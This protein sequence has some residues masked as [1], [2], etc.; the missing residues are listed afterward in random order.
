MFSTCSEQISRSFARAWRSAASWSRNPWILTLGAAALLAVCDNAPAQQAAIA[1][2]PRITQAID[3]GARTVLHGNVHP[4]ANAAN[5]R[6]AVSPSLAMNRMLLVLKRSDA[7]EHALRTLI[8]QQQDKRSSSFHQWLT[9]QR[10]GTLYGPNQSDI[11][12]VTTWLQSQGF[13][14]SNVSNGRTVIEFS[15]SAAQVES[16]FRTSIHNYAANGHA[17]QANATD[18]QIPTALAPVVA[19][20]ASINNFPRKPLNHLR[21]TFQREKSSGKVTQVGAVNPAFTFTSNGNTFYAIGPYDLATIYNITPLWNNS[22]NGSGQT[23]A[24]V[25]QTDI[26]PNDA[27]TFRTLFGLPTGGSLSAFQQ[28]YLN[29]IVNGPDPGTTGDE[30]EADIDT[31]WS[32]A[33]ATNALIDFVTSATTETTAGIDLSALY[34]VD[35]NLAPILS[36]SYGGCELGL[37]NAGN[38]FYNA[39]WEQAAAQGISVF[40]ASGDEGSPAC[41]VNSSGDLP[42]AA[43]YGLQVNGIGS[44]PYDTEIGGTDF[45]QLGN[46]F[47]SNNPTNYWNNTNNSTNQSSAKGYIPETTWND[48]CTNN[49]F[50]YVL[51][52]SVGDPVGLCNDPNAENINGY[53]AVQ[54]TGGGGGPSSCATQSSGGTCAAGYAKPSWQPASQTFNDNVRD[55]PDFSL[56]ASAGSLSGSFYIVCQSDANSDGQQCNLNSPYADFQGYGGT[57]VSTPI[58]A[59]LFAI[60]NQNIKGRVGNANYYLYNLAAKQ[61][62]SSCSSTGGPGSS[63]VFN[64]VV[65]GTIDQPCVPGRPNCL[66]ASGDNIGVLLTD[67]GTNY[68]NLNADGYPED[69]GWNAGTGYDY[70][71]G[72][73]SVNFNNLVSQ[74]ST[75]SFVASTTTLALSSTSFKHGTPVTANVTVTSNNGTPSGDVSFN[76]VTSSG[77]AVPNSS[78]GFA[79]LNNG[80]LSVSLNGLSS[81]Q[82]KA[83][84]PALIPVLPGGSYNVVAHYGGNNNGSTTFAASD[85]NPVAVNI[86]PEASNTALSVLLVNTQTGSTSAV[87]TATYGSPLI[88]KAAVTNTSGYGVPT[89]NV[90]IT[91]N[92]T[93]VTGSPFTLNSQGSTGIGYGTSAFGPNAGTNA[94]SASYSGDSS[95]NASTA[96]ATLTVTQAVPA[97]GLTASSTTVNPGVNVTFTAVV[98]TTSYA[99]GPTGSVTFYNGSTALGSAVPVTSATDKNGFPEATASFSTTTL[100][101]GNNSIT[102]VYSGDTNF[103]TVTSSAVAVTVSSNV[104]PTYSVTGGAVTLSAGATSG[105]TVTVTAS[106]TTGFSGTINFTASLTTE[107]AGAVDPPSITLSPTSVTLSSS[108]ASATSTATIST[109]APSNGALSYPNRDRWYKAAGGVALACMLFFGIPARRRAWRVMLSLLVFLVSV[110]GVGCGGGGGNN[111]NSG[112]TAGTYAFTI[113]ATSGSS[114]QTA[115]VTVNV[116]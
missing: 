24:I 9:P 65:R 11:Q 39:I 52:D 29:I 55:T 47:G 44:T 32:G 114:S 34:I 85:S 23:I 110:A 113:T 12:A 102:A 40:I 109:T 4:L 20:I 41:D 79:P 68:G 91:N 112:T 111:G 1:N 77:T 10:F 28:Q 16:A 46:G 30:G 3:N 94:L 75:A 26:D 57:S 7:Q 48:S 72:L 36:E 67:D 64:D 13:K 22:L 107:P 19:G 53:D 31:Q 103:T 88:A 27:F 37:G 87:T 101:A 8:D 14:V 43:S 58:A 56:F 35:N 84:N 106:T 116:Q 99:S 51:G 95:F 63:C 100:P 93:A 45:D 98:D 6:G 90:A 97:V 96:T 71:T 61:S 105:N 2:P 70:A 86:S 81:G 74:W 15:G 108:T 59:G 5:D 17:Y 82:A 33:V 38:A 49:F 73:G 76:G 69:L 42:F 66:T 18:P 83:S 104:T 78:I 25:G 92:G 89:G 62:P 54:V 60:V 80:S 21:G 115:Q 50:A